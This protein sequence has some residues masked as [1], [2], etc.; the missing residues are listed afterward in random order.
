LLIKNN[1]NYYFKKLNS[2]EQNKFRKFVQRY[3]QTSI[4]YALNNYGI[5]EEIQKTFV[6]EL[7]QKIGIHFLKDNRSHRAK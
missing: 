4:L 5:N 7:L 6:N 1:P 2:L 3:H